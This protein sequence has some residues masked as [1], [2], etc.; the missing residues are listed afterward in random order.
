MANLKSEDNLHIQEVEDVSIS[1]EMDEIVEP[2]ILKVT[3]M[4]SKT[5]SI[6]LLGAALG[7]VVPAVAETV[8]DH[9]PVVV[10][11]DSK[12]PE[13][14]QALGSKAKD[15]V[16]TAGSNAKS[17]W[18]GQFKEAEIIQR[19]Q[20]ERDQ[21]VTANANLRR[22]VAAASIGISVDHSMATNCA[23]EVVNYLEKIKGD[24]DVK[25]SW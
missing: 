9:T 16:V 21:L 10:E 2:L 24:S 22:E 3:V 14:V 5:V 12:I 13:W 1:E 6:V 20:D 8:T 15:V 23:V 11:Q 4:I 7:V 19:L 18:Q 17:A 25:Q